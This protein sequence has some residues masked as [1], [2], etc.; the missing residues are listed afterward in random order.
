MVMHDFNEL[1][2]FAA[3]VE[4]GGLT[5]VSG[6][7]GLPKSTLSRRISQLESRV[8]QRL[9]LRQ[10]NRLLP[11]EAGMLFYNYCR[12]LLDLA[13]QSQQSLDDLKEDVSGELVLRIHD[14]FERGWLPVV[15]GE[16][17]DQ[18]PGIR[19][20][21][22]VSDR[23]P[24]QADDRV[25]DLWLWLG[26]DSFNGLRTER[27]GSWS[28]GLYA[29]PQFAERSGL[30]DHPRQLSLYPWVDVLRGDAAPLTLH[31]AEEGVFELLP[32]PSRLQANTLVLQADAIVRGKGIGVLPTWY[33]GR[34]EHAHPG[35]FVQCLQGWAPA[36]QQ[37]SLLYS[38]GRPPRKVVA[39][40]DWIRQHIPDTWRR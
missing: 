7:M 14:A 34:Y 9:L 36:E 21:L 29:S 40:T 8:G 11:T 6:S 2:V 39:L 13:E 23:K 30:P 10:S 26:S 22:I 32:T 35:S 16:F 4:Q 15:L 18:Y 12:Q 38:F 3:V 37:V 25:G 17:L 20:E 31:H 33:A 27:L 19:L 28:F 24:E 5:A 1:S